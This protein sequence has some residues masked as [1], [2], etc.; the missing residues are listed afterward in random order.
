MAEIAVQEVGH[1]EGI[2][3][4]GGI[5]VPLGVSGGI[6]PALRHALQCDAAA[7]APPGAQS[8]GD[9]PA[10]RHTARRKHHPGGA[11][12]LHRPVGR[13]PQRTPRDLRRMLQGDDLTMTQCRL[14]Q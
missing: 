10:G 11:D 1:R 14:V 7:A 2:A 13:G 12:R 5:P 8:R 4:H 3:H 6:T 9:P